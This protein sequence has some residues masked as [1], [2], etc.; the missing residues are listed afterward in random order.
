M[1]LELNQT[2][3]FND[4]QI[5]DLQNK[6]S[7]KPAAKTKNLNKKSNTKPNSKLFKLVKTQL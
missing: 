5:I 2:M 4:E 7:S 3:L 6:N 1:D